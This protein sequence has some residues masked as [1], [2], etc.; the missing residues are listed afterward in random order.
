MGTPRKGIPWTQ[1]Q[2][3]EL[4]KIWHSGKRI[5][6]NMHL[7]GD[8]SY[9]AVITHAYELGL[10]K[11]Q[12]CPRGQAPIAEKLMMRQL[13]KM[14]ANRFKLAH[15]MQLD[16]ATTHKRLLLLHKAGQ[17]HISGWE[18]R[19]AYSA[20]VPIFKAGKGADAPKP[21]KPTKAE[22]ERKRRAEIKRKRIVSGDIVQNVNP[23][24]I[25]M[26]QVISEAA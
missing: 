2:D 20:L 1:W 23:F 22:N 11:R 13:A 10:G 26:N 21:A 19:F 8:H 15:I 18:R 3:R 9:A 7:F 25:A 6:E 17:V 12:N 5:K 24:A 16:P 4:R 14:P